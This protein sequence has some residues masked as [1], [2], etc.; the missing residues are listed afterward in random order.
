MASKFQIIRVAVP[1]SAVAWLEAMAVKHELPSTSKA[2]RCCVN[3]AAQDSLPDEATVGQGDPSE[4]A[5]ELAAQQVQWLEGNTAELSM[6]QSQAMTRLLS[7]CQV[8]SETS[9]FGVIRC[10]TKTT[11]CDG[12]QEAIAKLEQ[13]QQKG[14]TE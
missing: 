13:K 6:T 12:A 1:S 2:V 14:A 8:A 11:L 5:V 3:F 4:L 10:K 9:V 7:A